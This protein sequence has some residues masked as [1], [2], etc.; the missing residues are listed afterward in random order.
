[1]LNGYYQFVYLSTDLNRVPVCISRVIKVYVKAVGDKN[2]VGIKCLHPSFS[3]MNNRSMALVTIAVN[4]EFIV[5]ETIL[6]TM[7]PQ[8]AEQHGE[9]KIQQLAASI[10]ECDGIIL[11]AK[12]TREEIL[13]RMLMQVGVDISSVL[14]GVE[15]KEDDD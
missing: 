15:E 4:K 1:M 7:N 2:K 8:Y 3:D 5:A 12:N 10:D 9:K 11:V 13:M 6:R 14:E